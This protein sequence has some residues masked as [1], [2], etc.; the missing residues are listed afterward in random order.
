MWET[1][2]K[3]LEQSIDE[4]E[5]AT[6]FSPLQAKEDDNLL[7][8]FAPNTFVANRIKDVYLAQIKEAIAASTEME[9]VR[10][11]IV[12]GQPT[13]ESTQTN[14]YQRKK[15]VTTS[16]D[17]VENES[18]LYESNQIIPDYSFDN[19]VQ[20][21]SNQL[22][23][24]ACQAASEAPGRAYNPIFI[25]GN[26]GL[27]KTHLL[28]A[29]ANELIR[30]KPGAKVIYQKSA[31]FIRQIV[32]AIRHNQLNELKSYYQ[33][34]DAW[35][36]DDI[37][38][39]A[40]KD[41]SQQEFFETFNHLFEGKQQIILTCD[42]LPKNLPGLEDRLKSR[43]NWGVT[44]EIEAPDIEL[45]TAVLMSKAE[46]LGALLP[47]EV[48]FYIAKQMRTNI[49]ELEGALNDIL[50]FSRFAGKPLTIETAKESLHKR[51]SEQRVL[52]IHDI[53]KTVASYAKIT[54]E[55]LCSSS[56]KREIARPRQLC[57]S[58]CKELTHH[59]LPEIGKAFGGRDHTTVMH[60]AKK[61]NELRA[62]DD[63][64][65]TMYTNL[66]VILSDQTS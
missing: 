54:I 34:A 13:E 63:D 57:M 51:F 18:P 20:G 62:Y 10:I 11:R 50:L 8:L 35:L 45:R 60:A 27:G 7:T 6:W 9:T 41:R 39:L 26:T 22:S 38:F 55:D 33:S 59:S 36:V 43:F 4:H 14:Q 25:Y 5:L 44:M 32:D 37:Q 40:G 66:M 15:P 48:A 64:I 58:L 28:H 56:R 3:Y 12:T 47:E 42:Q 21:K 2:L 16:V 61:I 53:Q 23:I 52:T 49:R 46:S 17:V 1:C 19:F 65:R 29:F 24:A 30:S 31:V